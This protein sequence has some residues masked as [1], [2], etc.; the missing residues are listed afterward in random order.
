[1][2]VFILKR[3]NYKIHNLLKYTI[4]NHDE[5]KH[6]NDK[7]QDDGILIHRSVRISQIFD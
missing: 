5:A 7:P 2:G 4:E 6:V 1:V 3:Q